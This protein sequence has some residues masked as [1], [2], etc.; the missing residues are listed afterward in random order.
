MNY[1]IE[2]AL[3][4]AR[5]RASR[6]I[7]RTWANEPVLYELVKRGLAKWNSSSHGSVTVKAVA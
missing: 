5:S 7:S 6:C 2:T 4:V 3:R 1:S